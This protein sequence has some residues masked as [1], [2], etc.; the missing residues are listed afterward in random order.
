VVEGPSLSLDAGLERAG[1]LA[2]QAVHDGLE[3]PRRPQTAYLTPQLRW[4]TSTMWRYWSS[5][6]STSEVA[7]PVG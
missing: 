4:T 2:A 5:D 7:Q 1:Q 6:V 3:T